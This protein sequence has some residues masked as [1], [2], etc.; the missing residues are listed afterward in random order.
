[1]NIE[2]IDGISQSHYNPQLARQITYSLDGQWSCNGHPIR[3]PYAPEAKLSGYEDAES[4]LA[5][6]WDGKLEY[7]RSFMLPESFVLPRVLIHFGAVDQI[8]DLYVNDKQ[9]GHHEGGYLSFVMDITDAVRKGK[10]NTIRLKVKD[11][12]SKLYPYGKQHKKPHGMWYTT[13]SGIWKSVW[14]ENVP[15]EYVSCW[16]I[17]PKLS[18]V[19]FEAVTNKG[20]YYTDRLVIDNP[21][22]WTPDNPKLYPIEVRVGEDYF[23]SYFALRTIA[24]KE[25][26]GVNRVCLNDQP[27]FLHGVLDQGYWP[28]G[29]YTPSDRSRYDEDI[30]AMK[31][32]GYN[33]LR[34]HVKVEDAYFYFACD[35]LGIMVCQ[36]MVHN[37]PYSYLGDTIIPNLTF[38]R[39]KDTRRRK[40]DDAR[41]KF[42]RQHCKDTIEEVYNHP[43]IIMYTIF[44]EGWGQFESDS[45]Y[46]ELKAIDPDRL[47]DSTSGWFAQKKSD[48]D[49]EHIYFKNKRLYPRKRPM[50]LKECGGYVLPIEGHLWNTG[51]RYGYGAC[52]TGKQLTDK[53]E[54]LYNVMVIPAI[55]EG[56]CGCVFTQLSDVE[57]EINGLYTYDRKVCKVD[58]DR[59]KQIA[60]RVAAE[61]N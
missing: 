10:E 51:Q 29:I 2:L 52:K 7:V 54:L 58:K 19:M 14:L 53:I 23:T 22:N 30:L 31:E 15:E 41:R 56:L 11:T 5:D 42:F 16:K 32:L 60:N 45:I 33:L 47:F 4:V 38:K 24:I 39:R 59:M 49:S 34:K 3:V 13:V 48:F 1:M 12:L 46:E 36:D 35:R 43:C 25:I 28:D 50:F 18:E 44:N 40:G 6:D 27:I 55:K 8:A 61:I 21:I 57:N 9:I 37:G 17:S 20:N 26:N